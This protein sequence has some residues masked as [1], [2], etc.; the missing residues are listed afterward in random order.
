VILSGVVEY[1]DC[2]RELLREAG[3]VGRNVYVEVPLLH[4]LRNPR[5][6]DS[7]RGFQKGEPVNFFD[8]TLIRLLAQSAGLQVVNQKVFQ[9]S[10]R[11]YAQGKGRRESLAYWLRAAALRINERLATLLFPYH[12]GLLCTGESGRT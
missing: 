4:H 11:S 10:P 1:L 7:R 5:L 2:P 3:R 12:S 9:S 8:P 6:Q